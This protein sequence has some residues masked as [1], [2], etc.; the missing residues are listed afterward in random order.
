MPF[1][2]YG[3]IKNHKNEIAIQVLTKKI[4]NVKCISQHKYDG[5]NFQI[6]FEKKK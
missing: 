6:I 2:P 4:D 3:S 1:I 5:S